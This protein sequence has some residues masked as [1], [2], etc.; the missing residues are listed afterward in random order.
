MRR[1]VFLFLSIAVG[2]TFFASSARAEPQS[3]VEE[4]PPR[5]RVGDI[6]LAPG[7]GPCDGAPVPYALGPRT[8]YANFEGAQLTRVTDAY[9]EN[10]VED[11]SYIVNSST[12]VIPAFDPS[13]IYGTSGMSRTQVING[14]VSWMETAYAPYDVTIT[15]TRPATGPYTMVLFGGSA[16]AVLGSSDGTLG[17]S[18]G[19]CGDML[20][21][22]I[23]FA[24]TEESYFRNLDIAHTAQTGTHELG[25]SYSLMHIQPSTAIM[26]YA[27]GYDTNVSNTFNSTTASVW[28]PNDSSLTSCTG[29]STQNSHQV[30]L[31][32]IGPRGQDTT[33]PDITITAPVAGATVHR[34][35]PIRATASDASGIEHTE[36]Q[37]AGVTIGTDNSA[38]YEWTIPLDAPT[39]EQAIRVRAYD[40]KGNSAFEQ[41]VVTIEAG[42][43][44][45]CESKDDCNPGE[46]C[47]ENGD[48]VPEFVAGDIGSACANDDSCMDP[49]FCATVGDQQRCTTGCDDANP[50]P[51]GFDCL[52]ACWPSAHD[53]GGG[54][55]GG[56]VVSNTTDTRPLLAPLLLMALGLLVLRRRRG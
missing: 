43:S 48:C 1:A 35:D 47:D 5:E 45:P 16:A 23:V 31:S 21:S 50:C 4:F 52:G 37:V 40:N 42:E 26:H 2:M 41:I 51:D 29:G 53:D 19:D 13:D 56:C 32:I 38:P 54:D 18:L 55:G 6:V 24:F 9:Q 49:Y 20:P 8:I 3:Q 12:E 17:V 39:G 22:Q 10:A 28:D 15:T 14:I 33:N 36:A 46:I 11:K 34:G 7:L 25:H 44:P 30:L 27:V